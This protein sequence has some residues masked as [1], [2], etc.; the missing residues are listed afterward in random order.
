MHLPAQGHLWLPL[1]LPAL[2]LWG[3]LLVG[4]PPL[5]LDLLRSLALGLQGELLPGASSLLRSLALGQ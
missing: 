1:R 5:P 3:Q 2:A 4:R